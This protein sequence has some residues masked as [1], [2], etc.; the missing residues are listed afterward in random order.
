MKLQGYRVLS[1]SEMSQI[2]EASL[3]LMEHTG[4]LVLSKEALGIL[5]EGGA[6]VDFQSQSA[7][8]PRSLVE[9]A[10]ASLPS[11]F[12][13]YCRE[14]EESLEVGGDHFYVV[15]GMD[16]N[17]VHDPTTRTRRPGTKQDV[18]D[19]AR[20]A[21]AL[22]NIDIVSPQVVPR[23]VPGCSALI[24]AFEAVAN[25]T[26]KPIYITPGG[27]A[28]TKV[29]LDMAQE[30]VGEIDLAEQPI[31]MGY[32]APTSPLTWQPDAVETL[33]ETVRR[34]I[35]LAIG[36]C[37]LMG[38]TSPMTLAGAVA[39]G[40]AEQLSGIVLAYLV[41]KGTPLVHGV[42][43]ITTDMRWG[44]PSHGDPN[45]MLARLA[46]AQMARFY[47]IPGITSGLNSDAQ[48]LDEQNGWE[49]MLTT[50]VLLDSGINILV[51]AGAL[52]TAST[53]AYEQLG[54]DDEISGI[55]QQ[56]LRGIEVSE[57]TLA[58]D[59]IH[60]VGPGGN[61]LAQMHT[62]NHWRSDY[63]LPRV[64]NRGS[65]MRWNKESGK[66]IVALA[67]QRV[68]KLMAE[69]HPKPLP[70]ATQDVLRL[71]R[72][73]FEAEQGLGDEPM[74]DLGQQLKGG[75]QRQDSGR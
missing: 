67:A 74:S 51:D 15:A 58:L 21:D 69:H 43:P 72:E 39:Q 5:A 33:L 11:S 61:F 36:P 50:V 8:F 75:R 57:E 49:K 34:G 28:V 35:P 10:L 24:H 4:T 16:A 13:V 41:R 42:L 73:A 62:L 26:T 2:H 55:S 60:S 44:T 31:L 56:L 9:D 52:A 71:M 53:V 40:N 3:Y 18:A 29:V 46:G 1:E 19:F 23:D 59:L 27:R 20:L 7:R 63:W 32:A 25:N 68:R 65:F 17:Y 48:C 6:D 37:P 47:K 70:Q 66:D 12:R 30:I 14:G 64:S 45:T 38:M 22:P 54:L